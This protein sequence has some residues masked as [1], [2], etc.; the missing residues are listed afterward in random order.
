MDINDKNIYGNYLDCYRWY[1]Y[2][3]WTGQSPGHSMMV[4][5]HD[6]ALT[7]TGDTNIYQATRHLTC[8]ISAKLAY[9]RPIIALVL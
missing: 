4:S 2:L 9:Y 7:D 3:H 8:I 1:L 6:T 5:P